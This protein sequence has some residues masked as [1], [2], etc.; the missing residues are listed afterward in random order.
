[1]NQQKSLIRIAELLSR[2]KIET[3]ILNSNAQ[4]DINIVAEDVLIPIL[5]IAYDCALTNA[6][7][8]ENDTKFPAIDLID[9][10]NRIAFQITSTSTIRKARKTIE[11]IVK[12]NF[13][14]QFDNFYIYII[15]QKQNSYDKTVLQEATKGL[16]EFT[17]KNILD[18]RDLYQKIASLPLEDIVKVENLLEKQFADVE[19]SE[20]KIQ[21]QI[22]NIIQKKKQDYDG[23]LLTLELEG[24]YNAREEWLKKKIFFEKELVFTNDTG[25]KFT[26]Y[27]QIE[28]INKQM[29]LYNNRISGLLDSTNK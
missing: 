9:K 16:F 20:R 8:S 10:Q 26:L 19:K 4:L 12:N 6:K 14:N 22:E 3:N 11:G 21:S 18:E 15:T 29:E 5:N 17:E 23:K 24:A 7:Y 27:Q 25:Q 2:F 13:H 28:E 1:M